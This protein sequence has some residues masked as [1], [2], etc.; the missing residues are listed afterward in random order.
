[1]TELMDSVPHAIIVA[2]VIV[3]TELLCHAYRRVQAWKD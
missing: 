2:V 1:M 3:G